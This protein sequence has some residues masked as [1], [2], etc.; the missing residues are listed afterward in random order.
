MSRIGNIET[1]GA[2]R[3]TQATPPVVQSNNGAF[4][5]PVVRT[6]AGVW[7]IAP[8]A[9]KRYAPQDTFRAS[10]ELPGAAANVTTTVERVSQ[11]LIR[12]RAFNGTT[13]AAVDAD[14]SLRWRTTL[15]G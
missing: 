9:N 5:E 4:A 13:G 15:R 3:F 8:S 12:V 10:A 14:I 7:E 6:G 1:K 11:T 2:L